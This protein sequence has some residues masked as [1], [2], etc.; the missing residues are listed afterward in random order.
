MP[1]TREKLFALLEAVELLP[2][3][4]KPL[5]SDRAESL[6]TSTDP[7][8]VFDV[9]VEALFAIVELPPTPPLELWLGVEVNRENRAA[10]EELS[11]VLKHVTNPKKVTHVEGAAM[12]VAGDFR[13]TFAKGVLA[14]HPEETRRELEEHLREVEEVSRYHPAWQPAAQ[15]A[16]K[17]ILSQLS[18]LSKL[19][20]GPSSKAEER[21]EEEE[22]E[23]EMD[24]EFPAPKAKSAFHQ[25]EGDRS[26]WVTTG[27]AYDRSSAADKKRDW[28]WRLQ[29]A[30]E[31]GQRWP[32]DVWGRELKTQEQYGKSLYRPGMP[33]PKKFG[34]RATSPGK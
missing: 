34:G 10:I 15:A 28:E 32:R 26:D 1:P 22:E 14:A 19:S 11:A 8:E 23:D 2:P 24:D 9:A 30:R 20:K 17:K 5:D 31:K 6:G 33:W 21:E 16:K 13:V 27:Q 4:S 3:P 29:W 12:E 18:Q 7:Q 25:G